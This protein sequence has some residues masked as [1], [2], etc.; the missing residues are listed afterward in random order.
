MPRSDALDYTHRTHADQASDPRLVFPDGCSHRAQQVSANTCV[1]R[2]NPASAE[3]S[4]ALGEDFCAVSATRI[5]FV[6]VRAVSAVAFLPRNLAG[7][8]VE[9]FVELT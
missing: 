1:A 9:I 2:L 6:T 5:F 7:Q 4:E 3:R 8:A